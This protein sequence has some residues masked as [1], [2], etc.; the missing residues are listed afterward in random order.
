[1]GV[2]K[3]TPFATESVLDGLERALTLAEEQRDTGAAIPMRDRLDLERAR[4][5]LTQA[6][7]ER[8]EPKS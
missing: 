6:R 7:I 5:G 3:P 4:A 8:K 2:R 1:M